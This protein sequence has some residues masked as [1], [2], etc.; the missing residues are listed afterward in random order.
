MIADR[1]RGKAGGRASQWVDQAWKGVGCLGQIPNSPP[2]Q[3]G[4]TFLDLAFTT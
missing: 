2:K 3:P 4:V 1:G